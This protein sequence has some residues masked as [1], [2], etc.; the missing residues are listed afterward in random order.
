MKMHLLS[1]IVLSAL[2]LACSAA[3]L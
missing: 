2:S 1:D 3:H